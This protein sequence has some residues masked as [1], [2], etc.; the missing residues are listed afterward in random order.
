MIPVLD[1]D[2]G[3]EIERSQ[4]LVQ[5][6]ETVGFVYLKN[7]G[8]PEPMFEGCRNAARAFLPRNETSK[9]LLM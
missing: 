2:N 8:I 3:S 5:Y 7:H 4:D 6:L 9:N 1:L